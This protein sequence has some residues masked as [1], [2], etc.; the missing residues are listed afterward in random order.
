MPLT[1]QGVRNWD[2]FVRFWDSSFVFNNLLALFFQKMC[3]A[4]P[5]LEPESGI[6]KSELLGP[7]PRFSRELEGGEPAG[8]RPAYPFARA[9][10]TMCDLHLVIIRVPLTARGRSSGFPMRCAVCHF[11]WDGARPP[12]MDAADSTRY[13]GFGGPFL[14]SSS[15]SVPL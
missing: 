12:E 11:L 2:C 1:R 6:R 7:F 3:V 5:G 15:I 9:A 10:Y 14:L 13:S 8:H 4:C